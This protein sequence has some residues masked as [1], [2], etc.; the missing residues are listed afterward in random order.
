M[1]E[2]A[3]LLARKALVL[4]EFKID[5][6]NQHKVHIRARKG[7]LLSWFFSILGL[8]STNEFEIYDDKIEYVES[9]LSGKIRTIIP[10]SAISIAQ[11]GFC[12]PFISIILSIILLIISIICFCNHYE[13]GTTFPGWLCLIIAIIF[14]INYILNKSLLVSVVSNSSFVASICFKRSIIEGVEINEKDAFTVVEIINKLL[15]KN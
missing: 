8:D 11:A 2:L 10:L 9:S 3:M 5:E 15:S 14:I 12:K 1:H 4:Q 6:S 7:G 13:I